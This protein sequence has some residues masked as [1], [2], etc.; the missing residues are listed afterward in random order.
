MATQG[1]DGSLLVKTEI[2]LRLKSDF[3]FDGSL[4]LHTGI[5]GKHQVFW[6]GE[7]L[8]Q[9]GL[10]TSPGISDTN[11]LFAGTFEVPTERLSEGEHNILIEIERSKGI[12]HRLIHYLLLDPL[13]RYLPWTILYNAKDQP[14]NGHLTSNQSDWKFLHRTDLSIDL[15][16]D[17]DGVNWL[18]MQM[19]V[20]WQTSD[21]NPIP[22]YSPQLLVAC[23]GSYDVFWD[24]Q[25]LGSSGHPADS[26]EKEIPGNYVSV[27]SLSGEQFTPGMHELAFRFSQNHTKEP[28]FIDA[29]WI[30]NP[31]EV[32]NFNNLW[33]LKNTVPVGFVLILSL[34][35]LL[36]YFYHER[37]WAFLTIAAF[38][39]VMGSALLLHVYLYSYSIPYHW[40]SQI[41]QCLQIL[42]YSGAGL[43]I[44][45]H[46][47]QFNSPRAIKWVSWMLFAIATTVSI[48]ALDETFDWASRIDRP[49]DL[50]IAVVL[51]TNAMTCTRE[52]RNQPTAAK[53]ALAGTTI[54]IATQLGSLLSG[55][56]FI[57]ESAAYYAFAG[58]TMCIIVSIM[59]Q[60]REWK[61]K[62]QSTILLKTELELKKSRLE[63]ELLKKQIQPHFIMNTLTS[64]TEWIESN[65]RES[66]RFIES[67]AEEFRLASQYASEP[68]IPL[69]KEI[70]ICESYLKLMSYR[71]NLKFRLI[72]HIKIDKDLLSVN[73]IPPYILHSLAE[74]AITHN[75][76]Q[77][78]SGDIQFELD[79]EE[80]DSFLWIKFATPLLLEKDACDPENPD[81]V[82]GTGTQYVKARLRESF[83]ENWKFEQSPTDSRWF[84][85]IQF[86]MKESE[87]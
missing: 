75:C 10:R 12:D 80:K 25:K 17:S 83:G 11:P 22:D 23:N 24:G 41:Y 79:I 87:S 71:E 72:Q 63:A 14:E 5:L 21:P 52:L 66:I 9:K 73:S 47:L 61:N 77:T 45:F 76:Y 28:N 44:L 32:L 85:S 38:Y 37:R 82:E 40:V 16:Q 64:L 19:I 60:S 70:E 62:Y 29:I 48:F 31:L 18:R 35:F 39:T 54:V 57:G 36:H 34:Y 33:E 69:E 51:M 78:I 74:N 58:H 49:L 30:L 3:R 8:L 7:K 59:I 86:P 26:P 43:L 81:T 65:P 55:R 2:T 84:T 13:P 50:F 27:T 15:P 53:W 20:P 6:D 68:V 67:L 56:Q 46:H 42:I 1:Y 4:N